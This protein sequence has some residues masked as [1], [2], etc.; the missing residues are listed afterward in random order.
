MG[1]EGG[2]LQ[3]MEAIKALDE[4]LNFRIDKIENQNQ[5]VIESIDS[6]TKQYKVLETVQKKIRSDLSNLQTELEVVKQQNIQTDIVI[7]GVPDDQE[8]TVSAVTNVLKQYKLTL[9]DTDYH[10]IYRLKSRNNNSGFTPICVELNSRTFKEAIFAQKRKYGPVILGSSGSAG[11]SSTNDVKKIVVK[12]RM[13]PY[14]TNLLKE[15]YKFKDTHNY[16]FVWF[17]EKEILL[18][19]EESSK[20]I[21]IQCSADLQKLT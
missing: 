3:I 21:R 6:L 16:K 8:N 12:H 1:L 10:R 19:K 11:S 14:F 17:Q 5:I 18:K 13:T 20:L 7:L 9:T 15:A 2:Q 4:K